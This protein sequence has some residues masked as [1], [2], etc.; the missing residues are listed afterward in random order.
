METTATL[1]FGGP[2]SIK[3]GSELSF[4]I[5]I[6]GG[7][8]TTVIIDRATV[9]AALGNGSGRIASAAEYA[10]VFQHAAGGLGLVVNVVNSKLTFS[11]DQT[12]YPGYGDDA[13]DFYISDI[14]GDVDNG[15]GF[16]LA[17]IDITGSAFT[18][19]EYISGVERMLEKAIASASNLGSLQARIDLQT[20]FAAKLS[21][22]IDSGIGRLVDA[23]MN[24][25]STRLKAIQTQ[26][27]LA[28]Q[29]LS[30]ANSAP[31][32]MLQLFR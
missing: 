4:D 8:T 6:D 15:F 28:I 17:E 10:T 30:I 3:A 12:L 1:E 2:F 31:E 21:D 25:A 14:D 27:Q 18:L 32:T 11:A 13:V 9:N 16:D 26:Q 20:E 24:E 29:S 7:A 5:S 22:S 19:D 23:D